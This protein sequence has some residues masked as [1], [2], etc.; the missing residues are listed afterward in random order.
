MLAV[1][2]A[3]TRQMPREKWLELRRQGIGGS[4]A[5]AILGLNPYKSPL[6]VYYE[7]VH[8]TVKEESMAMELGRE[9]EPFLRRRFT[10]WLKE[11][12]GFSVSVQ[13][14]PF[15]LQHP[16]HPI[17]LANLDGRF[18]HPGLGPCG[19][20]LKTA[21]EFM[22]AAWD[23]DDIPDSCYIQVQ[24]YMAVTGLEY[25][26]V[27]FL[28]G[29]REFGA[30]RVPRNETVIMDMIQRLI[31]FWKSY[32]LP[33]VT[34]APAGLACDTQI[35]TGLYPREGGSTI[36]LPGCQ[37][38]YDAYKALKQEEKRIQLELEA[39]RQH[40]MASMA[41]AE[42]ALVGRGK[43][44]WKTVERRGYTVAPSSYRQMR[45]Y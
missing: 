18:E 40:F 22:R 33:K 29:N 16:V 1:K 14:V 25:F 6:S 39:I 7:K 41:D 13:E 44:T 38:Q 24:H 31:K 28:I 12:E 36:S 23:T 19:L 8:N 43:V 9:L 34:P 45:F 4:D 20:E 35:L 27:A 17:L 11:Q 10:R 30:V 21:G 5:A 2:L 3:D 26:Y 42:T 32:V 15:M 37:A